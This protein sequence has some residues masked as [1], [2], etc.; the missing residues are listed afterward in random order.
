MFMCHAIRPCVMGVRL[1]LVGKIDQAR[2]LFS[3]NIGL[4]CLV[5]SIG[6]IQPGSR[7]GLC[8]IDLKDGRRKVWS[9]GPD[10]SRLRDSFTASFLEELP[11]ISV[12]NKTKSASLHWGRLAQC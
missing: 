11:R 2:V 7:L 12:P 8:R 1:G 3:T 5:G 6:T 4:S 9:V 10:S